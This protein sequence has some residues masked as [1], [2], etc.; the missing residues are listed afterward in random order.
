MGSIESPGR[1]SCVEDCS[2]KEFG[3]FFF[4]FNLLS[5]LFEPKIK[6]QELRELDQKRDEMAKRMNDQGTRRGTIKSRLQ[7]IL[8]DRNMQKKTEWKI[9][10]QI[11]SDMNW[12]L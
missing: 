6:R 5:K 1:G 7:K 8:K 9:N 2:K 12:I 3:L 11:C 10:Y 4:L